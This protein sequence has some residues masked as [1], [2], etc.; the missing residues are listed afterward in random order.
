MVTTRGLVVGRRGAVATS[1]PLATGVGISILAAGGSFADAAIATSAVLCVVEPWN[2]HLGGDAFL[3]VHDASTRENV[4]L[5]GSGAAPASA[6]PESY[7]GGIP[8]HGP[9]AA[10]VPGLVDSWLSLHA[11][12]GKLPISE[13]LAPA[14]EYAASGFPAGPRLVQ[15]AREFAPLLPTLP[16]LGFDGSVEVGDTIVQ[17]ELAETL[18][19]IASEGR[20]GFYAGETARLICEDSHG[21]FSESDLFAH[22]TRML[23]PLC[24]KYRGRSVYCQPPPSQGMIL[25]LELGIAD[26][27]DLASMDEVEQTH[28]LVEAKK[29]GF[30]VRNKIL[31]DPECSEV[32]LDRYLSLEGLERLRREIDLDVAGPDDPMP[33]A[34]GSDTTYFL[35]ADGD[36]NAVSFIQSVFHNFGSAWMPKGTGIVMN[37]RLT[38]FSLDPRSPNVLA[39]GKSPAQ[40]L[41]AWLATDPSGK[42]ELVGG[43]P[44]AHIQVQTNLQLLVNVLDLGM[45]PQV[46]VEVPRWQHVWKELA[47]NAGCAPHGPTVLE[48]ENRVGTAVVNGLRERGHRVSPIKPWAHGSATQLLQVLPSG[49]YAVGS[50]PRVDGHA[51]AL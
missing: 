19:R 29:L 46:A 42:L 39:P 1:Q 10:T 14:I 30:A 9:R 45:N 6:T 33:D 31:A 50:D 41:N 25:A 4:A 37:N 16:A 44:G 38:G 5:N 22:R 51:A 32:P 3:I 28:V 27:F 35:V 26:G 18:R 8:I 48:I 24:V 34:A 36:G 7:S 23:D 13:L 20:D 11:R 49:A 40:T 12:W 43:T 21:H 47:Q 17:P 2:S 15:K